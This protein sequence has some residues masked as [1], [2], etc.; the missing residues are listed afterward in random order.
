MKLFLLV[1]ISLILSSCTK[2]S[3]YCSEEPLSAM[4]KQV[5]GPSADKI[6]QYECFGLPSNECAFGYEPGTTNVKLFC[7]KGE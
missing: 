5:A 2:N 4:T 3:I 7:L 6:V 1:T